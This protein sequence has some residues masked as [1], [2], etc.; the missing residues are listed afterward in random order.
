M[1]TSVTDDVFKQL[2]TPPESKE[3]FWKRFIEDP[4]CVASFLEPRI[5][6]MLPSADTRPVVIIKTFPAIHEMHFKV[7]IYMPY[8]RAQVY[9]TEFVWHLETAGHANGLYHLDQMISQCAQA[10]H[11]KL[12]SLKPLPSFSSVVIDSLARR[13]PDMDRKTI[14]AGFISADPSRFDHVFISYMGMHVEIDL[15]QASQQVVFLLRATK[16]DADL[17]VETMYRLLIDFEELKT[18]AG[19]NRLDASLAYIIKKE[20]QQNKKKQKK[21]CPRSSSIWGW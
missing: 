2:G 13:F 7:Y 11:D 8:D 6:T 20:Q 1:T 19:M 14:W 12:D 9:V 16:R 17:I 3:A 21:T 18:E 10:Y 15:E 5:M 4:A